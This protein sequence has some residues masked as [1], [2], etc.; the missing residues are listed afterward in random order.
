MLKETTWN[1]SDWLIT[2]IITLILSIS[3]SFVCFIIILDIT[4][5]ILWELFIIIPLISLITNLFIIIFDQSYVDED[6]NE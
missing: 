4:Q 2:L 3:I 5:I 1:Q 6:D